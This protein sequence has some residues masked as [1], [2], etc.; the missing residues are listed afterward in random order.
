MLSPDGINESS[1]PHSNPFNEKRLTTKSKTDTAN[2]RV[3]SKRRFIGGL[4]IRFMYE[5]SETRPKLYLSELVNKVVQV[6]QE[7]K[8]AEHLT[9]MTLEQIENRFGNVVKIEQDSD[10]PSEKECRIV[11]TSIF[12]VNVVMKTLCVFTGSTDGDAS[13]V[14]TGLKGAECKFQ[15]STDG[16]NSSSS[17]SSSSSNKQSAPLTP[18]QAR[19]IVQR[20]RSARQDRRS[21]GEQKVDESPEEKEEKDDDSEFKSYRLTK[22]KI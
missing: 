6:Y 16:N 1:L 17:S 15:A 18:Q 5:Q 12:H 8:I 10:L 4:M 22:R 20:R 14:I 19:R 21:D 7:K 2:A 9:P 11:L 3:L 13:V